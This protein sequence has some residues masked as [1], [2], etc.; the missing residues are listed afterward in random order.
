MGGILRLKGANSGSVDFRAP[1][2]GGNVVIEAEKILRKDSSDIFTLTGPL[3]GP[4]TFTIDPA[5]HGD[6]TGTVRI[7]GGLTVEGT[8][9]TINSQTV[10]TADKNIV[11]AQGAADSAATDGAGITID[12]SG[13]SIIYDN[14][15]AQWDFNRDVNIT[16]NVGIGVSNPSSSLDVSGQLRLDHTDQYGIRLFNNGSTGGYIGSPSAGEIS[17]SA[18]GGA[19]HMRID[20]NGNVGIGITASDSA[21]LKIDGI[22]SHL[23]MSDTAGNGWEFRGAT[24]LIIYDDGTEVIR[25]DE[26]GRLGLGTNSPGVPLSVAGGTGDLLAVGNEGTNSEFIIGN[27]N[28]TSDAD[29]DGMIPG[30]TFGTIMRGAPN[31]H[32]VMALRE[33][34][35]SDSFT[36]VSG[37]GNYQTDSAFDTVVAYFRADGANAFGTAV[38]TAGRGLTLDHTDN[39]YGIEFQ[40][41][42]TSRGRIIQEATGNMYFDANANLIFRN[43]TTTTRL[44]INT[45]GDL[46]PGANGTQDLGSSSLRWGTV[47]TSDLSLKNENGDWTIVEGED[48]LFLYNN[49]KNKVYKFALTEVDPAT[50]PAKKV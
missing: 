37:G 5:A 2:S 24:R 18:S 20:G 46:I 45:S 3:R 25:V 38:P 23:R 32:V 27:W 33:N 44:T 11:L 7:L 19:E 12:T 21:K 17:F 6:S 47:Y 48:D 22:G 14:T 29:I 42:G 43:N 35:V 10:T 26:N 16:G 31:G 4:S 40:T 28:N 41:S 50:A 30:S 9:T 36:I 8:T 1:D 34:D 13:A 15:N 39:Y 49:K